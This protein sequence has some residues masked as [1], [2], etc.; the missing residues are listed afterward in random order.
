MRLTIT[1]G[2]MAVLLMAMPTPA[3][4]ATEPPSMNDFA[5]CA[6]YHRML[7]GAHKRNAATQIM[8][9]AEEEK[10][11]GFIER[12]Q[13]QAT[14]E[15]GD[16][17]A[18]EIWQDTWRATLHEMQELINYNYDNVTQLRY[19][20]KNRCANLAVAAQDTD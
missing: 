9:G 19:R 1:T 5:T 18:E 10:M 8:A 4:S 7:A 16:D 14:A 2:L 13:A 12:A 20:Y 17:L 6:V 11:H 15:Y 3:L